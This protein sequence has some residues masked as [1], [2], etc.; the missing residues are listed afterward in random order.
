MFVYDIADF[1]AGLGSFELK[2]SILTL[3]DTDS[4]KVENNIYV[5]RV[6]DENTLEVVEEKS[7]K[8]QSFDPLFSVEITD[9]DRLVSTE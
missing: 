3:K 6:I 1:N 9:C 8:I 7:S 2:N 5:F 4:A